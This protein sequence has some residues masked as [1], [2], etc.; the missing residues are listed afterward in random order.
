MLKGIPST[1]NKDLQED[2]ESSI[3]CLR[4]D[5]TLASCRRR[6]DSDTATQSLKKCEMPLQEELLATDLADYLVR[7]GMPFRK[8]H[9]V[10]GEVV[11]YASQNMA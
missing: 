6:S 10:V 5:G 11:Q 1:Y 8:A 3:R 9:H 4:H 7:K 2:K